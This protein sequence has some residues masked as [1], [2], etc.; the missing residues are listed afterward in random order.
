MPRRNSGPRL[1]FLEKRHTYYI[2]WTERGRSCERST[3]TSD[4]AEAQVALAEFLRLQP[5]SVGP[6]DPSEKLVTDALVDY[7]LD[8]QDEVRDK[9]RLA[10]AIE[11]LTPFWAGRTVQDITRQTCT[12]YARSRGRYFVTW[13][14]R[15]ETLTR[16]AFTGDRSIAEKERAQQA[17]RLRDA[18]K[19]N[20]QLELEFR[21]L[22]PGSIRREL[23]VL[24]AA[25]NAAHREGRITRAVHVP[26][27][28]PPPSRDRFLTVDEVAR[29]LRAARQEPRARL[30]L[31]LFIQIALYT[32]RRKEAILS[33]R[34]PAVGLS[35]D[36][37]ID[38]RRPGEAE[39]KKRR[40]KVMM[41]R[42]LLI[43]LRNARKRGTDLGHVVNRDGHPIKDIKKSFASACRRAGLG[44]VTIHT[45][46]HTC[47]TW[48]MQGGADKW[49]A[50][51]YLSM[52]MDTL[53]RV[54][55]HHHPS[56]DRGA[57]EVLS[58]RPQN[59]RASAGTGGAQI[60]RLG[61]KALGNQ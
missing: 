27:P 54:Y 42:K 59:V 25:V 32:G 61:Q 30:H 31:P 55:G 14:E 16:C 36:G 10:C 23:T 7:A 21:P 48:L 15:G 53:E 34:W 11:A 38:F 39:T 45:L 49:A 29:L 33:L 51:G 47:A 17:A 46:R 12:A 58:R 37:L 5:G 35:R 60:T 50:A 40:G 28:D 44:S 41:P 56:H 4:L 20:S 26:L 8:R 18:G 57:G 3:G 13:S 43:P 19:P 9:I 22:S 24:R 2:C 52:S 6:R 1:R